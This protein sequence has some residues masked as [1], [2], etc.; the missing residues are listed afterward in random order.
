M[1]CKNCGTEIREDAKFCD[2]CGKSITDY[3]ENMSGSQNQS[4]Q[5][6]ALDYSGSFL[7]WLVGFFIPII[8]LILYLCMR[9]DEP[10]KAR[11]A[12]KG[13]L[14]AFILHLVLVALYLFAVFVFG[15]YAVSST[16]G[17]VS[18]AVDVINS[19]IYV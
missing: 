17:I 9:H 6:P 3:E 16:E 5:P 8:G 12:G 19:S 15:F 1:Y 13:A 11:S 7:M 2:N 10:G 4:I 18:E 14:S